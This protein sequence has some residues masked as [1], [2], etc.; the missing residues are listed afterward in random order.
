M[1]D[2]FRTRR[3]SG[4]AAKVADRD[5]PYGVDPG[6]A[7]RAT[8]S[9]SLREALPAYPGNPRCASRASRLNMG[10]TYGLR[11]SGLRLPRKQSLS[12]LEGVSSG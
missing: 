9:S 12:I 7:L 5:P 4:R 11:S 1:K 8:G 10:K 6:Y 3:G 2:Y